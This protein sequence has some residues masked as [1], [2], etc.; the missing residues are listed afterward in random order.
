MWAPPSTRRIEQRALS[1]PRRSLRLSG[2]SGDRRRAEQ[3]RLARSRCRPRHASRP[4]RT[5]A[6]RRGPGDRRQKSASRR[7]R[8]RNDRSHRPR[9]NDRHQAGRRRRVSA[10]LVRRPLQVLRPELDTKSLDVVRPNTIRFR[11]SS[12]SSAWARNAWPTT[13]SDAEL[14]GVDLRTGAWN[15]EPADADEA[16]FSKR[17]PALGVEAR[18]RYRLA[19]VTP[20]LGDDQPA[21]HLDM[22]IELRNIG[23][24]ATKWPIGWMVPPAWC[25]KARGMVA[26]SVVA[27]SV[28]W[29]CAT[30]SASSKDSSPGR[31]R[32]PRSPARRAFP[33]RPR[34]VQYVS[35]DAQYFTPA[36]FR[37]PELE[38]DF[39]EVRPIPAGDIPKFKDNYSLTDVSFRLTSQPLTLGRRTSRSST[40]SPCFLAR[41]NRR[42]WTIM[43]RPMLG[44]VRSSTTAGSVGSPSRC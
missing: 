43:G 34:A 27:G 26:R 36:L 19:K 20:N 23:P 17:L 41:A 3:C 29:A 13:P 32:R 18:K 42:C 21:Y 28:R 33:G 25:S 10:T 9:S 4:G 38:A 44:W 14:A 5:Q 8:W 1:R 22:D 11:C 7:P 39:I 30:L 16:V 24:A 6:G 15:V 31:F 35:V 2:L 40:P 12:R 37:A